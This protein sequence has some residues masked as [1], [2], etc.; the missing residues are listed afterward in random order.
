[1]FNSTLSIRE[2]QFTLSEHNQNS[3]SNNSDYEDINQ[4]YNLHI[5][6]PILWSLIIIFGIIGKEYF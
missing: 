5:I 4:K 6:V 2:T 3:N 1:M